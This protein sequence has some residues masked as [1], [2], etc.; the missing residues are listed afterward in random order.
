MDHVGNFTRQA[1]TK[2][3]ILVLHISTAADRKNRSL[4]HGTAV[5]VL[6]WADDVRPWVD[7]VLPWAA[8]VRPW[9]DDVFP[10]AADVRP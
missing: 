7:D 1:Q 9:V 2:R 5:D 6:P 4:N 8:D 3:Y 10:W